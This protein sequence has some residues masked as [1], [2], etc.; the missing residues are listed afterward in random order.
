MKLPFR[1]ARGEDAESGKSPANEGQVEK[2]PFNWRGHLIALAA[3]T[4]SLGMLVYVYTS[5]VLEEP[6]LKTGTEELQRRAAAAVTKNVG[7][8][9]AG[10]REKLNTLATRAYAEGRFKTMPAGRIQDPEWGLTDAMAIRWM[11]KG[12]QMLRDDEE[13]RFSFACM[14]LTQTTWNSDKA[15]D[16]EVHSHGTPQQH[17]DIAV[18]VVDFATHEV[19]GAVIATLKLKVLDGIVLNGLPP[20]TY[21]ELT[22]GAGQILDARG[23]VRVREGDA[24]SMRVAGTGWQL[25]YWYPKPN[26]LA[27]LSKRLNVLYVIGLLSVLILLI[28]IFFATRETRHRLAARAKLRRAAAREAK[29]QQQEQ[30]KQEQG[31]VDDLGP[32]S[33]FLA[34]SPGIVVEENG[35]AGNETSAKSKPKSKHQTSAPES[36]SAKQAAPS[37]DALLVEEQPDTGKADKVPAEIFKAYDI[38]G[39]VGKTLTPEI[40][41]QIG[42]AIGSEAADRGQASI[43]VAR[44][45]RSSGE[46]LSKALIKGLYAAGREVID[47]GMVPTPLLYFATHALKT[48]AG[49]MLTGSH[50]PPDHNGMKIVLGGDTLA[51]EGIQNLRARIEA[52]RLVAGKGSLR[53]VDVSKAYVGQIT[54]QLMLLRKFT[55]V[56]DCG[57]GV[58]GVL[59]PDLLRQ[60]GCDVIE[61]YTDVDGSFPNHHPDPS[62]PDNLRDLIMMVREMK[63]DLGLAFDGDGDRL[64]VVTNEG[65]IIWPDRLMM[66]FAED[67]LERVKGAQIIYDVKCSK[68]LAKIISEH[69]GEPLMWKTGHSLVKAKLKETGAALAGEMSGHIFFKERWYGFDDALYSAARLLEVLAVRVKG[70]SVETVFD[71]YPDSVNTPELHV[72]MPAEGA[73]HQFMRELVESASF[74]G[75]E[76]IDIDGLR[77]EFPHGWGLVRAS[78]TTPTLVLRFEAEDEHTLEKIQEQFARE[79]R[80]IRPEIEL[81][82]E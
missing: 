25:S 3:I 12:A 64:G 14:D 75:A 4:A 31:Q 33:A 8:Q 26:A 40:V 17:I 82:F 20:N 22:Q 28:S 13:P 59:A 43:C 21:A 55:V 23:V 6:V 44:D 1:R 57:N 11:P 69:G 35:D 61:L 41:F 42:R 9:I 7:E 24:I 49:V 72:H 67:I 45:G 63:A 37:R 47:I 74:P 68:N 73:Q 50:N 56:V 71:A 81:P 30:E 70:G 66:L 51:A 38:R 60:M 62:Q 39:V 34:S 54:K 5:G 52:E 58:A 27:E 2:P 18:P 53:K 79:M 78:N 76:I 15:P 48:G 77:V 32:S 46:A 10:I 36:G 65:T 16:V 80:K 19:K 29:Q